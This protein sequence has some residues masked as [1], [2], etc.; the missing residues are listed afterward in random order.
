[1]NFRHS[2]FG[3][4]MESEAIDRERNGETD[5]RDIQDS[6]P[7]A[8]LT[9]RRLVWLRCHAA[10]IAFGGTLTTLCRSSSLTAL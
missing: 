7:P 6:D 9:L 5:G 1:M 3:P 4:P 2:D 8:W 10:R